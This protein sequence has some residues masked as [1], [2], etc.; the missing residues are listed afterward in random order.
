MRSIVSANAFNNF[1]LGV[2]RG[3]DTL[4]QQSVKPTLTCTWVIPLS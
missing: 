3:A 4:N 1:A 2:S